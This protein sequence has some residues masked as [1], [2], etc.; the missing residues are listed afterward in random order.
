[1]EYD[2]PHFRIDFRDWMKGNNLY[3]EYP[4]GGL[5]GSAIG[6]NPFKYPGLL[7]AKPAL[8]TT[9]VTSSL[10]RAAAIST[11]FNASSTVGSGSFALVGLAKDG[12]PNVSAA[13]GYFYQIDPNTGAMTAMGGVGSKSYRLGW[14]DMEGIQNYSVV[15]SADDIAIINP[16][17]GS[18]G[19]GTSLAF[20]I[21][22]NFASTEGVGMSSSVPHPM[23]WFEEFLYVADGGTL[24]MFENYNTI[25]EDAFTNIPDRYTVTA[26][27]QSRSYLLIAATQYFSNAAAYSNPKTPTR[28]LVWDGYSPSFA[29]DILVDD[30]VTAMVRGNDSIVYVWTRQHFG[31]ING[32]RVEKLRKLNNPVYKSQI[33]SVTDGIMYADGPTMV[34]YSSVIPGGTKYFF[35]EDTL[36]ENIMAM[37]QLVT[38]KP[39]VFT[40]KGSAGSGRNLLYTGLD[41]GTS[42]THTFQF[43]T[44][45]LRA[46]CKV[47]HVVIETENGVGASDYVTVAYI[48]QNG[49]TQTCGT[50]TGATSAMLA[51]KVWNF[52]VFA[53]PGTTIIKPLITLS[54]AVKLRSVEFYYAQVGQINNP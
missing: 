33:T 3:D 27:C 23:G 40:D 8:P 50:F 36:T 52:D 48:D 21:Y 4:S 45:V 41:T 39:I 42:G 1:M 10:K 7:V 26:L 12:D 11:S 28:I 38:D 9:T 19:P 13:D 14:S 24:H 47:R 34:R 49:T 5:I 17:A 30:Q 22:E 29:D 53:K 15:T 35:L 37:A 54:G 43:N 44:R 20:Q 25:V 46:T 6:Y 51:K 32:S 16:S 18:A 2:L 31:Y